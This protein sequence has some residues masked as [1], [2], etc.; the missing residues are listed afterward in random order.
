M[1]TVYSIPLQGGMQLFRV[2][3]GEKTIQIR[4]I[5][6][7]ADGGG[8]FMDIL[9][10]DGTPILSCVALRCGHNILGQYP[11]LELGNMQI[12]VDNDDA[13]DPSYAD[14]GKNIQLYWT[15]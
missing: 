11:H 13:K 4:L 6:R 8:W 15:P 7:E 14:M 1:S 12:M 2:S 5:W 10:T 3:L 9:E